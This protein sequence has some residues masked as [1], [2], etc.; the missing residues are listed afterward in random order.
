MVLLLSSK[1]IFDYLKQKGICSAT[2]TE[3]GDI[4]LKSAKNF[5][6]LV[7]LP[8]RS[9][10]LIKQE[11]FDRAGKTAGEF[12]REWRIQ[13]FVR[14]FSEVNNL[15]VWLPEILDFD[16]ENSILIVKYL[17]EY[18]NLSEFYGE[19]NIFASEIASSIG[20]IIATIHHQTINHQDYQ[21]FFGHKTNDP[22]TRS[23][24]RLT[25]SLSRIKPEIFGQV[26]ADG[27]KFFTLYQRYDSLGK[28]LA[29]LNE[30]FKPCCLTH[31]D[32]KLNNIL[33]PSSPNTSTTNNHS[34]PQ[35][36]LKLIDWERSGWGDPALDLGTLIGS[37]LI[38]WLQSLVV[39]RSIAIDE[40]LRLATIPLEVLQP[41]L[42]ALTKTYIACFPEIVQH[43]PDFWQRVMQFA[44]LA[45][46]QSIQSTLQ[47]QKSFNNTGICMLQVAK[48]LLCRPETSISS[49][50]GIEIHELDSSNYLSPSALP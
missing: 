44:G 9:K 1:N 50:L 39:S 17:D 16:T 41:S 33:I 43:Y 29:E 46:I 10:L 35:V 6:L 8:D 31:N 4:E 23:T 11:R 14:Q 7:T 3:F 13:E 40:S 49:V 25:Q 22:S 26:P 47:Y 15:R 32:L 48:S 45:L 2:E 5:N 36:E 37:Y 12:K 38:I 24:Q 18:Q 20:S 28:A 27:L 21:D 30:S 34:H 42:A 19:K